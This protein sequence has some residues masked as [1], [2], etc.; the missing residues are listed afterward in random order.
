MQLLCFQSLVLYLRLLSAEGNISESLDNWVNILLFWF[1]YYSLPFTNI[2]YSWQSNPFTATFMIFSFTL[3]Q[4]IPQ[5]CHAL[6]IMYFQLCFS[7][8]SSFIV[9]FWWQI[10]ACFHEWSNWETLWENGFRNL[11][12][13]WLSELEEVS[14]SWHLLPYPGSCRTVLNSRGMYAFKNANRQHYFCP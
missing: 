8:F 1:V 10:L 12:F 6:C 11:V 7:F 14:S 5:P 3:C 13:W 2:F 4:L 9:F